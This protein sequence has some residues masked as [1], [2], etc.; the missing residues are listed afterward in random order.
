MDQHHRPISDFRLLLIEQPLVN[1]YC[2]ICY[3]FLTLLLVALKACISKGVFK[4]MA[5]QTNWLLQLSLWNASVP[6]YG[7][8]DYDGEA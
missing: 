4:G 2:L 8:G 5:C 7:Y 6:F 1:M 3:H